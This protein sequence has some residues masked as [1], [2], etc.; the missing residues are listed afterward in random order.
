M[1]I[2][3]SFVAGRTFKAETNRRV[4]GE[5][6][7]DDLTGV[8]R[9]NNAGSSVKAIEPGFRNSAKNRL[10]ISEPGEFV[11]R[12][13]Q[14]APDVTEIQTMR[15]ISESQGNLGTVLGRPMQTINGGIISTIEITANDYGAVFVLVTMGAKF[16]KGFQSKNIGLGD[17]KIINVV[18]IIVNFNFKK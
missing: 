11:F 18:N 8:N 17:K 7:R 9:R 3:T 10:T 16:S 6:T 1:P 15:G 4:I 2:S 14:S 13:I 5:G 12:G